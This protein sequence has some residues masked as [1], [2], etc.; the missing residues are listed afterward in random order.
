MKNDNNDRH[1]DMDGANNGSFSDSTNLFSY[2]I[3]GKSF[4][5]ITTDDE[6]IITVNIGVEEKKE[7]KK[8]KED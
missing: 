4:E 1:I 5:S 7:N 8:D 3:N 6:I 2:Y